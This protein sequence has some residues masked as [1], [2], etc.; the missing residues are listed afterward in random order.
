M[1]SCTARKPILAIFYSRNMSR[2]PPI[3]ARLRV[4]KAVAV[5]GIWQQIPREQS[6]VGDCEMQPPQEHSHCQI[7][8]FQIWL[9]I[10]DIYCHGRNHRGR[11]QGVLKLRCGAL[12]FQGRDLVL[13]SY[14]PITNFCRP[15]PAS[16]Q[17]SILESNGV[18]FTSQV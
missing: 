16:K 11:G 7:P 10:A 9:G 1:Q 5:A 2:T 18:G 3:I 17:P 15:D 8:V 13:I 12:R 14:I 4:W 6:C